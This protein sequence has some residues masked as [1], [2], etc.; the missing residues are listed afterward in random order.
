MAD[1]LPSDD[2]PLGDQVQSRVLENEEGDPYVVDQQNS[3]PES[4]LGSG[5]WPETDAPPQPPAPGST[6]E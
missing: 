2:D 3:G 1:V 6:E 5:E 4:E